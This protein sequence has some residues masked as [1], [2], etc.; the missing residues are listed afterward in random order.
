MYLLHSG[1]GK[2]FFIL[3]LD[4]STTTPYYFAM[5]NKLIRYSIL[6]FLVCI[7]VNSCSIFDPD[8][9]SDIN[10]PLYYKT[11][12]NSNIWPLLGRDLNMNHY[13]DRPEVETRINWYMQHKGYLQ[14][15]AKRGSPYVFYILQELKQRNM[16]SEIALLPIIESGYNPFAYSNAGAAGLWQMMPGTASGLSLRQNW[17]YDGRRDIYAST[18]AALN[19]I[20]Y[21]AK[22]FNNDWLLVLAAYNSGDGTVQRAIKLNKAKGLPT[23]FWHLD[24]PSQTQQYVPNLLAIA[25]I[26]AN[27]D[28]Y[29]IN[30]PTTKLAP[31]LT[32]VSVGSQI[33]LAKAAKLADI[34]IEELYTL[35]P[36]YNRWATDPD[37]KHIL[38]I[39]TEKAELFR[40]NLAKLP[41]EER[42]TWRRYQVKSGDTLGSIADK[43]ETNVTLIKSVNNLKNNI[44]HVGQILLIPHAKKSFA[45]IVI[46][47]IHHYLNHQRDLPGPNRVIHVVQPGESLWN[48]ARRYHL[49]IPQIRYW[50]QL[51]SRQ[52]IIP[53]TE[54]VLWTQVKH[55][56]N[57]VSLRPYL[58]RHTVKAGDSLLSLSKKYSVTVNELKQANKLN[59]NIVRVGEVLTIPPAKH[60]L[61]RTTP[62]SRS[63]KVKRG[64]S[65]SII[66]DRYGF[67]SK[68][69]IRYNNLTSNMIHSGQ[70]LKIP[71]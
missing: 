44:I 39:P 26:L 25:T 17:W 7:A 50:N 23:D 56:S 61:F 33:D 37:G 68:D 40:N 42:V 9:L 53:G 47:E 11:H 16:P 14:R 8:P 51:K 15:V 22:E 49:K 55:H 64:D 1:I 2:T 65:L 34:S 3:L 45:H 21:L 20:Q 19:Y 18:N 48:I 13:S 58:I 62:K 60:L 35:N 30:W 28:Q 32:P 27:P 63:Y 41:K 38:L 46:E 67:T 5:L 54:L 70:T 4:L 71:H 31:F 24:L 69:L 43:F 29:P 10:E 66:A 59:S 52:A 36:G 6:V 12:G 57:S